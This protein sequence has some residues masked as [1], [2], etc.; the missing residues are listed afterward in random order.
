MDPFPLKKPAVLGRNR[1][2]ILPFHD[3]LMY[4]EDTRPSEI[5][6]HVPVR[7]TNHLTDPVV[8]RRGA[9]INQFTPSDPVH[10]RTPE[11]RWDHR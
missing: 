3:L 9:V 6:D 11:K 5:D 10:P 1:Q 7:M 2:N 8:H 4:A